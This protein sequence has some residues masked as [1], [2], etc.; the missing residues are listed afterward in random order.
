MGTTVEPPDLPDDLDG[1]AGGVGSVVPELGVGT[2][3]PTT[4]Q[5]EQ[6]DN[7][8]RPNLDDRDIKAPEKLRHLPREEGE[9]LTDGP[10]GDDPHGRSEHRDMEC[11]FCLCWHR[12]WRAAD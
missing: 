7:P 8:V 11:W 9:F 1:I 4:L 10:D 3:V 2:P 6:I 12:W 5:S